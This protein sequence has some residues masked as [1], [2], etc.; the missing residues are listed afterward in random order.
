MATLLVPRTLYTAGLRA[1]GKVSSPSLLSS[2]TQI[3]CI[4]QHAAKAQH[5]AATT[6]E[7]VPV[8]PTELSTSPLARLPTTSLLRSLFLSIFFTSP[9]LFRP[10]LFVF[11]NIANSTSS[12]LNPDKNPFLRLA[13]RPIVY[14]QFCAGRNLAE[15]QQTSAAI[16]SLGFSGVVLCYA[17][18]HQL[19]REGRLDSYEA[20]STATM[21]EEIEDWKTGNLNTLAMTSD[22]DWLGM[23]LTGGG[24]HISKALLRGD[25]TPPPEFT[26][27]MDAIC[28]QA[29]AQNTR[30]WIDA[31]QQLLQ[32][33][34]DAWAYATMR[35]Y[36]RAPHPP[37]VFNTV[38]AYLKTAR[39]KVQRQLQTAA[40]EGWISAIKLV[41][42][43]Y[44]SN[45]VRER[46]HDT[47]EDTDESY[48]GIVRDLLRGTGFAVF[49]NNPD[50]KHDLL[51]AGHNNHSVRTA[52]G[53]AT[54][55]AAQGRLKVVPEFGQLQ[56]MADDIGCE[57]VCM[58][59]EALKAPKVG[60][61]DGIGM[62]TGGVF[63]PR[64][65]KCL[66]WGSVQECMQYLTRRLVENR[67]AA[68]R[69]KEGAVELRRELW[70]RMT[71]RS[72]R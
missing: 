34:I 3:A 20:T 59:E 60:A 42:G 23:K 4:S 68:D 31:E 55:L 22:G 1:S 61:A 5:L 69:M 70:R 36:N 47:K 65:Y 2:R 18:E 46:I 39:D 56:G 62:K 49:E 72:A 30:I 11:R 25:T 15:I 24:L 10:G 64:V 13:I 50:L 67:G 48:N 8:K 16:K 9:I 63:V 43:A 71:F 29:R 19:N 12:I 52:A 26:D 6:I 57:L 35:K 51:L 14:D 53:L 44:I 40:D 33:A 7:E 21:A 45:D 54:Q 38:Q 17:K 27:A 37:L 58:G 28:T 32:P 66:T 41:R